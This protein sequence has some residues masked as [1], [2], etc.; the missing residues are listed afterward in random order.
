[1]NEDKNSRLPS[2][3]ARSPRPYIPTGQSPETVPPV[4]HIP[5]CEI[6][7]SSSRLLALSSISASMDA[8][9]VCAVMPAARN[10]AEQT[11]ATAPPALNPLAREFA[12]ATAPPALNP[13]AREFLPAVGRATASLNPHAVE[14]VPVGVPA[15]NP[16]A[17]EFVP[18]GVPVLN[19]HAVEFVPVGVPALNPLARDFVPVGA[20][21]LNPLAREFLPWWHV[22]AGLSAD[23]PEFFVT[24]PDLY[25]PAA[26]AYYLS[27]AIPPMTS[28]SVVD[29][30]LC[31]D[32]TSGF[33]FA[34]VEFLYQ[35]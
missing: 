21:T 28:T 3:G 34:F 5:H 31:G 12:P 2:A 14:F 19:P 9:Q 25:Y 33:R 15:L 7:F 6:L 4:L 24:S 35:V 8:L 27:N 30:R 32:P 13:L 23:A 20:P 11:P 10:E 16:H 26:G 18:V 29:C 17:V 22:G 1:M